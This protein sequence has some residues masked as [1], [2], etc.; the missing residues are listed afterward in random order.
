MVG[1]SISLDE[2]VF[3]AARKAAEKRQMSMDAFV[4]ELI[5]EGTENDGPHEEQSVW[6][7]ELN[8]LFAM[9]D[10]KHHGSERT[11]GSLNREE[12]YQRGLH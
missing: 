9:S 1:L 11:V 12:I 8:R 6:Q 2:R 7:S 3:A 4:E 10:Q 5:R